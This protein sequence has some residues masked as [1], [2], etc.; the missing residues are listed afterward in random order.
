MWLVQGGPQVHGAVGNGLELGQRHG[1]LRVMQFRVLGPLEVTC[2]DGTEPVMSPQ[3]RRVL[4]ALLVDVGAVV[5]SDRLLAVL[6]GDELPVTALKSLHTHVSRLRSALGD[7]GNGVL[8]TRP[9]GYVLAVAPE[10]TDAGLF[11]RRVASARVTATAEPATALRVL[12]EALA[13]WRGPAYADFADEPFVRPEVARLEELRLAAM[14]ARFDVLL[15]LGGHGEVV[16]DLDT[17]ARAHPLRERPQAQL[18]IALYRSGRQAEALERY[19]AFRDM[20]GDELG[21]LPSAS[22]QA[23]ER[24]MLQQRP[25]LDWAPDTTGEGGGPDRTAEVPHDAAA[26]APGTGTG[27]PAVLGLAGSLSELDLLERSAQLHT[28][29]E[30]FAA[31]RAYGEGRVAVIHGEA[32]VG[33][34]E[35][36]RRFCDDH[37]DQATILWGACDALFT[38]RPLGPLRD[39]AESIGGPFGAIVSRGAQ[40]Y[41]VAAAL[42]RELTSRRFTVLVLEDLHW[43]DE[44][45]IDVLR[46]LARRVTSVPVLVLASY[47]D[48]QLVPGHPLQSMLGELATHHA[49]TGVELTPLSPRA[50]V[51]LARH[52]HVDP[53]ELHRITGG[54]P[55][56][57][58]EALAAVDEG[59]PRTVRDAVLARVGRLAPAARVVLQAVAIAPPRIELSLLAEIAEG[60]LEHL[61]ACLASGVVVADATG[62]A[63]RHELARLAVD[64]SI[65]PHRRVRLHRSALQALSRR[66]DAPVDVARLA[67]HA[68]G[69]QAGK[70]VLELAPAAAAQ[71]AL[72]G[73]HREA[74]AHYQRLLQFGHLLPVQRQADIL[75]RHAYECYLTDDH[76]AAI[77]GVERALGLHRQLGDRAREGNALRL[78]SELLWCPGRTAEAAA[79][80]HQAVAL[81]EPLTPDRAFGLALSNVARLYLNAE[82]ADRTVAWSTRAVRVAREVDDRET[83]IHARTNLATIACLTGAADGFEQLAQCRRLAQQAGSDTQV[84]RALG[85]TAMCALRR[86]DFALA[87]RALRE[88]VAFC[89]ERGQEL[90]LYYLRAYQAVSDLR[91]GRWTDAVSAADFVVRY[92]RGSA[93]PRILALV[94]LGLVDAR[95]GSAQPWLALDEAASLAAETGEPLRVVPV[96]AAR[97]EAAW[98]DGRADAVIGETAAALELATRVGDP[99]MVGELVC[100]RRRAGARDRVT[101][102]MADPHALTIEGRPAPAA[103]RW[104]RLGCPYEAALAH[105]DAD[106]RDARTRAGRQLLELGAIAAE[107]RLRAGVAPHG[108]RGDA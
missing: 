82:D 9:P 24:D 84:G 56:F 18:M 94:V 49:I 30:L 69:A 25:D 57:V 26:A 104:A 100:W 96:A 77:A 73:A 2:G 23:L 20:I 68:A 87:D 64:A 105:A 81:L 107:R 102:R 89:R 59:V 46:L 14:E 27:M 10:R 101:V 106:G 15:A 55:F 63:Y 47:R 66:H 51:H 88:G 3:Q 22:L 83:E 79:A 4:A 71:A 21:L 33:K 50:V 38:P 97:A 48:D 52:H 54:N 45:T 60:A 108:S 75:E 1:R 40:P 58:S 36:M 8:L 98:L 12:D 43:A 17:L 28:L 44:A 90:H 53:D 103:Q 34:T 13:Q 42:L 19:R 41:D 31:V 65:T 95:R 99:W 29:E 5:S 76:T 61:D 91:Q 85:N 92:P 39:I 7:E 80:G 16:A 37:R 67:H 70:A 74:A 11:A 86:Y 93:S 72:L 78:L 35:V 62:V 32:G 6:W